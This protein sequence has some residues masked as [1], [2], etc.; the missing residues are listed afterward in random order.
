MRRFVLGQAKPMLAATL[1]L[2]RKWLVFVPETGTS[3]THKSAH[4]PVCFDAFISDY[5]SLI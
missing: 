2:G 5:G 1:G 4:T 3:L